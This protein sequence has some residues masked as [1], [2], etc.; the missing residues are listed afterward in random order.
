MIIRI[1]ARKDQPLFWYSVC[2]AEFASNST[3]FERFVRFNYSVPIIEATN[4]LKWK[5][6][7]PDCVIIHVRRG[8]KLNPRLWPNLDNDTRPDAILRRI[9][10]W[11]A[12]GSKI[13]IATNEQQRD[14]FQSLS[15]VYSI[16]TL[17]QFRDEL[18]NVTGGLSDSNIFVPYIAELNLMDSCKI[19]IGT[20]S[21]EDLVYYLTEDPKHGVPSS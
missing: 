18:R 14:F 21:E 4:F 13:Y 7:S 6:E 2:G 1:F 9:S 5:L 15:S 19:S 8:D 17:E 11:V 16:F 12:P 20:F 3:S 10:K